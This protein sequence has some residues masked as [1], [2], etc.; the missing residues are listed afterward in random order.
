M[1]NHLLIPLL[2]AYFSSCSVMMAAKHEGV[3][4]DHLQQA[5]TREQLIAMGA[6]PISAINTDGGETIE[7]YQILKEKG[8]VGRAMVH[9]ILDLSTIF[10]WELI[11]T[12]IESS[13]S[14]KKFYRVEAMIDENNEIKSLE[15][16]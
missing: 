10:L 5:H 7:T 9:G 16:R 14:Q 15:L 6:I 3:E 12:P 8:S 11:A 1:K 2:A 4:L 13:L